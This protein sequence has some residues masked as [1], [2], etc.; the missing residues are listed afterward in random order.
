MGKKCRNGP[1]CEWYRNNKCLFTHENSERND[2][3]NTGTDNKEK[4]N[5]SRNRNFL[6]Q[7]RRNNNK[8][9][10]NQNAWD[11]YY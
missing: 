2:S 8:K 10:E 1:T 4:E 3:S 7:E 9:R 11:H 5:E 6:E